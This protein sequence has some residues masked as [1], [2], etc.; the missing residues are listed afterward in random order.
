MERV[1]ILRNDAIKSYKSANYIIGVTYPML[2]DTRLFLAI[3]TH[4]HN[5]AV[6]A[7][8]ALLYHLYYHKELSVVPMEFIT[9]YEIFKKIYKNYSIPESSFK[10]IRELK[11]VLNNHKT[12]SMEFK[13]NSKLIISNDTYQFIALDIELLKEYSKH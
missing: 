10:V 13:R 11:T 2:Q 1:A 6:K 3:T 7:M 8:D 12:S 9:R 5:S 4:L